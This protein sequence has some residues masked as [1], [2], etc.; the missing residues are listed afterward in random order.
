M[1]DGEAQ[2][3]AKLRDPFLVDQRAVWMQPRSLPS[4]S[5]LGSIAL[6]VAFDLL[7][8]ADLRRDGCV[9]A[10]L[11]ALSSWPVS[12]PK[13]G[14]SNSLTRAPRGARRGVR[15]RLHGAN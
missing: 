7:Q 13:A 12:R 6:H 10:G 11:T 8:G 15:A 3:G 14:T 9:G 2:L 4:N 1:P 5:G